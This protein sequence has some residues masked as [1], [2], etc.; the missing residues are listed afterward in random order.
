MDLIVPLKIPSVYW[1]PTS[2]K[3][4]AGADAPAPSSRATSGGGEDRIGPHDERVGDVEDLRR[5]D[6]GTRRVLPDLLRAR[7]EV[8]A[9]SAQAPVV[10]AHDVR[11]DPADVGGHLLVADLPRARRGG[12]QILQRAPDPRPTDHVQLHGI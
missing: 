9:K 10:L 5:R 3:G 7:R 1:T 8:D 2:S 4:G 6:G 11:A 12:L